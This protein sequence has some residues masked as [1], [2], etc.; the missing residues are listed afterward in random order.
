MAARAEIRR[1][2]IFHPVRM[3]AELVAFFETCARGIFGIVN[4]N[5]LAAITTHDREARHIGRPVTDINHVLK[6][7]RTQC[8][9]HVV[10]HIL[11]EFQHA[12]VDAEEKLGLLGMAD[13]AFGKCDA[14]VLI[15]GE[16]ATEDL[17]H[18]WREAT[19]LDEFL[20]S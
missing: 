12:F 8:G 17:A 10:I 15:G 18:I 7:N 1:S 3:G 5:R 4:G 2:D 14:V 11:I 19:A 9:I 20:H 16:F 13:C 6:R